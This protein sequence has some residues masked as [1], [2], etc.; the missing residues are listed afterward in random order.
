PTDRVVDRSGMIVV[1]GTFTGPLEIGG[2]RMEGGV[3]R[4]AFIAA[5]SSLGRPL[6]ARRLGGPG[7]QWSPAVAIDRLGDVAVAAYVEGAVDL[8]GARVPAG[9]G[10][11]VDVLVAKLSHRPRGGHPACA[12]PPR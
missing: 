8:D 7:N 9:A 2:C 12:S 5:F 11:G 3:D 4:D 6:W 10:T 1:A